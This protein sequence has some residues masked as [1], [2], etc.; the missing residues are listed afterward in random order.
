MDSQNSPWPRLVGSH[1]LPSY[2]ILYVWPWGQH[3]NVILFQDSQVEVP[4]FSKFGLLW[5]RSPITFC[6]ELQLRWG[7][8]QSWRP[9]QN[10]SNDMWHATCKQVNQGDSW[11]LMFGSQIDSLIFRLSFHHNFCFKYP[12]GSYELIL[13]I[14]VSITFQ[15][16]KELFNPKNFDPWNCALKIWESI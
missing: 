2:S 6:P 9:R 15:W 13:N 10:L 12:N 7:L 1:H 4:K 3:L 16:Y 11:L 8:K 5:L 14:Y